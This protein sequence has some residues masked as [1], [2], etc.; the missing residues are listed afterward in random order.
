MAKI[1]K[2]IVRLVSLPKDMFIDVLRLFTLFCDNK[3]TIYIVSNA[4]FYERIKHIKLDC[5]YM[6]IH[7]QAKLLTNFGL[8]FIEFD[9]GLYVDFDT[10]MSN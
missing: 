10:F 9:F 2:E 3:A 5:H 6:E 1:T 7:Q 8:N 4:M